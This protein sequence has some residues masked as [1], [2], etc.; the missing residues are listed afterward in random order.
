MDTNLLPQYPARSDHAGRDNDH[1][2]LETP[3]ARVDTEPASE[4][5]AAADGSAM[6]EPEWY[7][8]PGTPCM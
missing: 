2:A 1:L 5:D 4:P 7:P 3:T 8:P 6:D